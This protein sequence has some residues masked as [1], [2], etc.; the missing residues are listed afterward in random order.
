[1]IT[2]LRIISLSLCWIGMILWLD[3]GRNTRQ[4]GY[5][6]AP[7]IWLAHV[8]AYYFVRL[9]FPNVYLVDVELWLSIIKLHG[10]ITVVGAAIILRSI[11]DKPK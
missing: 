3:W 2:V 5:A 10:V 9:F 7:V 11:R 4:W 6:I 8:S 1:M